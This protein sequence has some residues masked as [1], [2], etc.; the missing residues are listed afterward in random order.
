MQYHKFEPKYPNESLRTNEYINGKR[1][2]EYLS[3]LFITDEYLS[4]LLLTD[5]YISGIIEGVKKELEK[6]TSSS[7]SLI[8]KLCKISQEVGLLSSQLKI[9][10]EKANTRIKS[11]DLIQQDLIK[12]LIDNH[13]T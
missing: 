2:G 11:E 10:T 12:K 9:E 5:D 7:S 4:N 1:C 8:D 13:D 3:R 6:N